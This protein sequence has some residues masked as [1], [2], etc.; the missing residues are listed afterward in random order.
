MDSEAQGGVAGLPTSHDEVR[1]LERVALE[2]R[3]TDTGEWRRPEGGE[4]E[5]ELEHRHRED[6]HGVSCVVRVCCAYFVV[7]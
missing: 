7:V 1:E 6:M 3:Y 4:E 2:V 5:G